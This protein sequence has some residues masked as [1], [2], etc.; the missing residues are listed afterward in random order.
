MKCAAAWRRGSPLRA[1]SSAIDVRRRR[2]GSAGAADGDRSSQGRSPARIRQAGPIRSRDMSDDGARPS[3][4][5]ERQ[6]Q[7][8][9]EFGGMLVP[10]PPSQ[11]SFDTEL[12][13]RCVQSLK[14]RE[15]SVVVMTFYD[16]R[17]AAD[18]AESLGDFGSEPSCDSPSRHQTTARLHGSGGV[19]A[20]DGGRRV[21]CV[22][23]SK[24]TC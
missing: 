18:A 4:A 16:E 3:P 17:T 8:L 10:S 11:P 21:E 22:A 6:E 14:E 24:R 7:L 1:S 9:A 20:P 5:R 2:S 15:R 23:R 12:L 13:A 19:T